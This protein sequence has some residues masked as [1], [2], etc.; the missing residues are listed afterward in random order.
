[1]KASL[2]LRLGQQLTMTPQLQ[3]AIRLLQLSAVELQQEIRAALDSNVMLETPDDAGVGDE[4]PADEPA[5]ADAETPDTEYETPETAD[6]ETGVETDWEV[7]GDT[8]ANWEPGSS[9]RES[10]AAAPDEAHSLRDYLLWQLGLSTFSDTDRGLAIAL[11]DALDDDG[12][13][14]QPLAELAVELETEPAELETVLHRLQCFDPVGVA[15]RDLAECLGVQ[16]RGLDPATPGLA[17]ARS[18]VRDHLDLLA[19]HKLDALRRALGTDEASLRAAV[20]LVRSLN[21]RP[22]SLIPGD[23]PQ[24]IVPDVIVRRRES[25]WVVELNPETLPHVRVNESYAALCGRGAQAGGLRDQLA[26]ARWLVKSLEMRNETLLKVATAIVQ[27]QREF[28]ERGEEAMRPMI[29]KDIAD[30]IE[31]HESTV[32]RVTTQKYMHTPRGVYE[33]KYF[34]SSHVGTSDG[35]EESSTAIRAMI[36]RLIEAED[37]HRPLSDAAIAARLS[38]KGID[39]ARRT[40]TKY[41]EAMAIPASPERKALALR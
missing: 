40:V 30:A 8:T 39:I 25:R 32:S 11:I 7:A 38:A 19:T 14:H 20:D 33:F 36:R 24:Y 10:E 17:L 29:L 34:F 23:A 4:W 41:R 26:E 9:A 1:M 2:Q 6:T 16:L 35:G 3:Q 18:L 15:C 31:M 13:L 22:G 37:G 28:L 5:R 12:Y 27:R 21:P